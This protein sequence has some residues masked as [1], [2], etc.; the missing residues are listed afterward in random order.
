MHCDS[1][2]YA[3]TAALS[4]MYEGDPSNIMTVRDGHPECCR[5]RCSEQTFSICQGKAATLIESPMTS[6]LQVLDGKTCIRSALPVM[7]PALHPTF[8]NEKTWMTLAPGT[9]TCSA[10]LKRKFSYV[11]SMTSHVPAASVI[12]ANLSSSCLL[13]VTPACACAAT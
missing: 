5:S 6:Q 13:N 1:C 10:P 3:G 4:Y 2:V 8:E 11:L 12:A 9:V 7:P